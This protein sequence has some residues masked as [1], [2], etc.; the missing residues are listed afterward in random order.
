MADRGRGS[1]TPPP[2]KGV[3]KLG[4]SATTKL[5]ATAGSGSSRGTGEGRGA[6]PSD[7]RGTRPPPRTGAG[8]EGAGPSRRASPQAGGA[9]ERTREPIA[10]GRARAGPSER[11]NSLSG[12]ASMITEIA[13]PQDSGEVG[14]SKEANPQGSGGARPSRGADPF[15]SRGARPPTEAS[16]QGSGG[17]RPSRGADPFRSRGARPPTEASPQ[18]S[19]GARPQPDKAPP[20]AGRDPY[21]DILIQESISL[22]NKFKQ[23]Q[24]Q[25]S[26]ANRSGRYKIQEL[27]TRMDALNM[28]LLRVRN[29]PPVATESQ[30]LS[31]TAVPLVYRNEI[32]RVLDRHRDPSKRFKILVADLRRLVILG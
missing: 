20:A 1:K 8:P 31:E 25:Y 13:S 10:R 4:A 5:R 11:A 22:E 26:D 12:Q 21:E 18:G 28:E 2:P 17:A 15:R 16:P 24:K 23:V 32:Q 3:E 30:V 29:T 19:G 7:D 27:E 6:S 9:A 14:P